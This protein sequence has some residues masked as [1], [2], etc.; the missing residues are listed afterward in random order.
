MPA[1]ANTTSSE[2]EEVYDV[3]GNRI[4]LN[5]PEPTEEE[6]QR[7]AEFDVM[8]QN[9]RQAYE[10]YFL[11]KITIDELQQIE[12][13]NYFS[14]YPEERNNPDASMKTNKA[15]KEM[16]ETLKNEVNQ[17]KKFELLNVEPYALGD[18]G[19]KYLPMPYAM[20]ET[21]YWCGPATAVNIVNGYNGYGRISQ[22]W[23]ASQMGTTVNGTGLGSNWYNVLNA[24]TM[25]KS[26]SVA[27]G[28]PGWAASLAEKCISTIY[29]DRG[30]ALNT[31]MTTNTYYLPGYNSGMGN[32]YHY[33]AGYGFDSSDPSRRKISYLDPNQYNSAAKGAHTVT[34]QQMALATQERGIVY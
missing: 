22:S 14:F 3:G 12:D 4:Y 16:V 13:E 34:F 32:V 11:G 30:V 15:R 7:N 21:T 17:S 29:Y 5:D 26:Y 2:L 20:Q 28:S 19:Y 18:Y 27:W 6:L 25:G 33:V 24:S 10:A 8:A 1:F 31:L 9:I 23:A